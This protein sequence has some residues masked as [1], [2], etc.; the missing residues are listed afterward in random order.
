MGIVVLF[1]AIIPSWGIKGQIAAY[2]ETPGPS[3]GKLTGKFSDTAKDLYRIY[4]VLT[5]VLAVLLKMFD[6][7]WFDS[8]TTAFSTLATGGFTNYNNNAES[9]SVPVKVILILFMY[10]AGINFTLYYKFRRHGL[11]VFSRDQELKFYTIVMAIGSLLIFAANEFFRPSETVGYNL[12]DSLFHVVSI[13]TTTGFTISNYDTWPTFSRMVLFSF[14]FIGGCASST[15]GGIKVSRILICMKLIKRS[16][17]RRIHPYRISNITLN[18]QEISTDVAIKATGFVFTYIAAVIIGTLFIS[19]DG[20]GFI[21]SLSCASSCL[22]NIGPGFG[23]IGPVFTYN[24]LSPLTKLICSLLM[25]AGRLEL[26][27]VFVLFSQHYW[28]PDKS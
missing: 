20:Q 10:L 26:Y 11:K 3:K 1:A 15:A 5:L 2:A 24:I 25:I 17:S 23:L 28:N 9:F 18:N 27:T 14:F 16:F 6:M 19:L 12:L 13:N 4:I 7:S 8:I 22:A 21:T